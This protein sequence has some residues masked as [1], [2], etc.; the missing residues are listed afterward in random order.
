MCRAWNGVSTGYAQRS[1]SD[2][3]SGDAG[4]TPGVRR[5]PDAP[6]SVQSMG[7]ENPPSGAMCSRD[8]G[9]GGG[10][11]PGGTEGRERQMG[12]INANA[13][14]LRGEENRRGAG[15]LLMKRTER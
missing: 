5:V 11:S 2:S 7:Q 12:P 8:S 4:Q 3:L 9:R 10:R 14:T 13:P 15:S 6:L 1:V